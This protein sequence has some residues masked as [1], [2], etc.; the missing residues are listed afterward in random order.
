[1]E[2]NNKIDIR[3][4][5]RMLGVLKYL[6]YT[7]WHALAEYID[8]TIQSFKDDKDEIQKVEGKNFILK[9]EVEFNDYEKSIKIIDN[10]GG[11]HRNQFERA[12]KTAECPIDKN[13]LC[14]FGMGMKSAS[15]WFANKW[16]VVTESIDDEKKYEVDFDMEKII[17]EGVEN[18]SPVEIKSPR[19]SHGTIIYLQDVHNFPMTRTLGKIKDHLS[20]IYRKFIKER[21]IQLFINGEELKYEEPKISVAK[22][23]KEKDGDLKIWRKDISIDLGDI[24]IEG[25]AGL[26]EVGQLKKSGFALLRRGRLI[27]GSGDEGYRPKIIFGTSNSFTFQRLFGELNIIGAEVTH[28][29]NSIKWKSGQEEL[30]LDA[31]K[32]ELKNE[33]LDLLAQAEGF[34]KGQT[35][36]DLVDSA[37]EVLDRTGE[38][39]EEN[40]SLAVEQIKLT[41]K[42]ADVGELEELKRISSRRI[43]KN[44]RCGNDFWEIHL[45]LSADPSVIDLIEIG[46]KFITKSGK[47]SND[48]KKIGIRMSLQHPF[49]E[50]F[51]SKDEDKMELLW[52]VVVAF[53]IGEV[54]ARES[55][56]RN[57]GYIRS[58]ANELLKGFLSSP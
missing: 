41:D 51:V 34:R 13:G 46:D 42:K 9:I 54:L 36:K 19:Y 22:N 38:L 21:E 48:Y 15:C 7:P 53:S 20:S 37:K 43:I 52:R 45:E 57:A 16:K 32:R 4:G 23:Y 14:E 55:G 50:R 30:F 47:E 56:V 33:P 49:V 24:K 11:I 10:A 3:P 6:D 35:K 8:N 27:Q 29:K 40:I 39:I 28:T 31:L 5:M 2:K 25:F 26:M 18:I 12:F 17:G 1:M 44:V 58:N